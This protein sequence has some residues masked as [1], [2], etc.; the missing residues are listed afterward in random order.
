MEYQF[1]CEKC[2]YHGNKED[3]WYRHIM[4]DKHILLNNITLTPKLKELQAYMKKNKAEKRKRDRL[5]TC[6]VLKKK[7][8]SYK[9]E[10]TKKSRYDL[11]Q[12]ITY[13]EVMAMIEKR[14]KCH[15]CFQELKLNGFSKYDRAQF[16]LDRKDNSKGHN[17]D[18]CVLSCLQCNLQHG[19][20]DYYKFVIKSATDLIEQS[21]EQHRLINEMYLSLK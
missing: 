5:Y 21:K 13:E 18:N 8:K 14:P 3:S 16:S 7:L 20:K 10:D 4:T 6:C 19:V 11:E 12:F 1:N 9:R 2:N 15:Y 17:R